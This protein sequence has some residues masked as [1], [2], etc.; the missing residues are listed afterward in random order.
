[1]SCLFNS[2][3]TLL[4][5][6]IPDNVDMRTYICDYIEQNKHTL[7][8]NDTIHTWIKN[9]CI[10]RY[11][12]DDIDDKMIDMYVNDMR[13]PSEYGGAPEI[14]IASHIFNVRIVVKYGNGQRIEFDTSPN[15]NR[16]IELFW[17]G[18]HYYV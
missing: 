5:D 10:D 13:Q 1:M 7:L 18:N 9:T 11:N 8:K 15:T 16:T 3:T 2:L 12:E 17:T 4:R 6:C 14:A